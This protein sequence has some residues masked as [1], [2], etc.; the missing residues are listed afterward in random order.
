MIGKVSCF[1]WPSRPNDFFLKKLFNIN[2]NNGVSVSFR[3]ANY[4]D[5]FS[6]SSNTENHNFYLNHLN[7]LKRFIVYFRLKAKNIINDLHYNCPRL[8]TRKIEFNVEVEDQKA[9]A[10]EKF[11]TQI[12]PRTLILE[13][14]LKKIKFSP[15]ET[16]CL[17]SMLEG[18]SMN[19]IAEELGVS[20]RTVESYLENMKLKT[21]C[22]TK[23]KLLADFFKQ[24]LYQ[25]SIYYDR[26]N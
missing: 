9:I 5:V 24:H 19:K 21:G 6:F 25:P 12:S 15:R 18:K 3:L 1:L 7:L 8:L 20:Q 11:R 16:Q 10:L 4:V 23:S 14:D 2:I 13:D 17:F 22:I 26:Y